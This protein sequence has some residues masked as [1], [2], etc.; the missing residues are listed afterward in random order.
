[1]I[2]TSFSRTLP[3]LTRDARKEDCTLEVTLPHET[4]L[5]RF[6]VQAGA[7]GDLARAGALHTQL[8]RIYPEAV[9]DSG[10]TWN[11]VQVGTFHDRDQA[12]GLRRELAAIGVSAVV[13]AA[14]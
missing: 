7:F 12:E 4:F 5:P 8:A 3:Q 13:V 10:G 6:T 11:R 2:R 14:R 9:V 1:M